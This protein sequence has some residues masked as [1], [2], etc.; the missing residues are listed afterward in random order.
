MCI[1]GI[2]IVFLSN[3]KI[4]KMKKMAFLLVFAVIVTAITT[5]VAPE[6]KAQEDSRARP[7]KKSLEEE[8]VP[9][10]VGAGY[11]SHGLGFNL[12]FAFPNATKLPGLALVGEFCQNAQ[13][14]FEVGWQP[15]V[16][17]TENLYLHTGL[18]WQYIVKIITT[19]FHPTNQTF[20]GQDRMFISVRLGP[21]FEIGRFGVGVYWNA[22]QSWVPSDYPVVQNWRWLKKFFGHIY[23]KL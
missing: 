21:E 16:L 2:N 12:G 11:G 8:T 19:D 18:E 7:F 4:K 9:F 13:L 14:G 3:L 6:V 5:L 23:I 10:I 20:N 1:I 17:F 15:V 22:G